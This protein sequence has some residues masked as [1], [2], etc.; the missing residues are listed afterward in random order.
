MDRVKLSTG[1]YWEEHVGYSRAIKVG[2]MI[3]IS[4][5]TAVE[6]NEVVGV[7]DVYEQTVFIIKKIEKVLIELDSKLE[8]VVRIRIYLTDISLWK[9]AAKAFSEKF[10][11]IKPVQTLIEI[12]GLVD[13]EMLVEIEADAVI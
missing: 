13:P 2:N 9:E 3:F 12:K 7:G 4:G 8:D 1:T 11:D 6:N 5:T 10:K